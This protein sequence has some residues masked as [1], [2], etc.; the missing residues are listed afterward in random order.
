M[1]NYTLVE[2]NDK[3]SRKE[4]L[5]LPVR[6]YRNEKNWIRPLDEDVEKVFDPKINKSFRSGE[7]IR[8]I[9]LD[10]RGVTAGRVAAFVDRKIARNHD[11]PTGGMGF[12]ECVNDEK[13]AFILFDACRDWLA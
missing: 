11:Q 13:A 1:E 3:N 2:V 4:F 8:W 12:F 7:C 5:M 9:L 6:L 10:G